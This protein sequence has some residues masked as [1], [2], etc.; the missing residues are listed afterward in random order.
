MEKMEIYSTRSPSITEIIVLVVTH[1]RAF[2]P[3]EATPTERCILVVEHNFD[4][5]QQIQNAFHGSFSPHRLVA[6]A[7]GEEAM[8]FLHRRGNYTN[9]PRPD[10]VL[11]D[12]NLPDRDGR[13]VL[14]DIKGSPALRRI[15]VVVLTLSDS[16]EDIVSAYSLQGNCY[17]VKSSDLN[18]LFHIV[19]RIEEFWLG[20]VTLPTE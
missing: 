14:A 8:D 20:I 1:V 9:A 11:L 5:A 19:K 7:S 13:M 15:P 3:M 6:I 2:T 17:V 4:H 16:D 18:Q 10:L 12:L